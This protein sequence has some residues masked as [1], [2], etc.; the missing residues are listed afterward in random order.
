M[1]TRYLC[2]S[3]VLLGPVALA[4]PAESKQPNSI[5]AILD[6]Q[7]QRWDKDRDGKLSREEIDAVVANHNVTGDEAAAAA[8][9]HL[10][11][12]NNPKAEP[13]TQSFVIESAAKT[14]PAE[15]R[16]LA[17]KAQHFQADFVHFRSHIQSAPR[18][19]FVGDAPQ[20][21]G[22]HQGALGD[23]YFVSVIG[24]AIQAHRQR[25]K[26]MFHP[27]KDGSC[28]LIFLDGKKVLVRK[29]TDAQIALGS[30]AGPQGLWLNVLEEGFGQVRFASEPKKA[31]GDIP[32]D[33]I[34]R[35]GDPQGTIALLTGHKSD[36][37]DVLKHAKEPAATKK[38][39]EAMIV[40]AKGRRLMSAGTPNEKVT[41]PPGVAGGHCYA[42][43][44]FDTS[45]DTVHLWNPWGN[46]FQPKKEQAGLEN[47]YP[48]KDGH[49]D[50]SLAD[51][52][53]IFG[54][55]EVETHEPVNPV[56]K[57]R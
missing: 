31:A 28:E 56:P 26:E 15:R 50:V 13:L 25:F 34:S 29:L 1:V 41:L 32:L 18:D 5:A 49:F 24:A 7:F 27:Q 57:K 30:S 14:L 54:Y 17:S 22:M 36:F 2:L 51:F 16:D 40:G 53:R 37:F 44:G 20:L 46:N 45:T 47:G 19:L 12:R 35:G 10:Y 48:V 42:V 43:L 55:F 3:V 6:A 8:A 11:F 39:R 21:L 23:C 52:V 9:L 38:L 33:L 4:A